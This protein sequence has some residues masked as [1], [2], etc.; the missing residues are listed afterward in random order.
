MASH[1]PKP[2]D[3]QIMLRVRHM[4]KESG[5]LFIAVKN[6]EYTL[7]RNVPGHKPIFIG[8]KRSPSELLALVE[9]A[10][11]VTPADSGVTL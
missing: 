8:K 9:T 11:G 10:A 6:G 7:M 3:W 5:T 2:K 4:C 1:S